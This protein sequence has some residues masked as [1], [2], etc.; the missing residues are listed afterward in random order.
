MLIR[1][2]V[3]EGQD[4]PFTL[5]E[6]RL[7]GPKAGEVLVKVA[8]CG[9]CHTDFA[10]RAGFM[11]T[12]FPMVLGHEGSGV[13]LEAGPD[14]AFRPGQRV[15]FSYGWCGKC[16][17]CLEGQP[18]GC[19]ENRALNFSGRAYDGGHRLY[20]GEREVSTFFG[21]SAFAEYAVV[22]EN[23]LYP[24]PDDLPLKLAAPL[25]CGIQ[26]GSGAVLNYLRPRA[27]SSLVV[28]G[29]GI[30]GLSAV[31]A[32]VSA[33]C[34]SIIC[35]DK[36]PARLET[37]K[38]LG[39][40]HTLQPEGISLPRAVRDIL[41]GRGADYAIDCT[42]SGQSVR[43]SLGSI[44]SLGVCV[45]LGATG[46]VSFHCEQELMG[47]GRTLAGLVEGCSVP[48]E[49]L[50]RLL[51]LWRQGKFPFDR[52]LEFY[53]FAEISRAAEDSLSGRVLKAVLLMDET[54]K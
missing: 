28:A 10:A 4:G 50:P 40:T 45:V 30:V 21:Q 52:L 51:E 33:G 47:P 43:A 34:G 29:C 31:M 35:V 24:V 8:A 42:G 20:W 3:V 11:E 38:A 32:A 7:E 39:A 5:Q 17:A 6:L 49:F 14:S 26:T 13:V 18:Y 41:G 2:A 16:P 48:R 22:H 9:V 25:G 1:A 46:E 36:N 23:N 15:G 37:A 12:P 53:P 19:E 54:L 27:G 44:R